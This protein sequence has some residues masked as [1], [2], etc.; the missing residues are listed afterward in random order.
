MLEGA[1]RKIL[2]GSWILV[3]LQES[4]VCDVKYSIVIVFRLP[5]VVRCSVYSAAPIF[6]WLV[7]S[8]N[9][10]QH[11]SVV[12]EISPGICYIPTRS[13]VHCEVMKNIHY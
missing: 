10:V 11:Y 9:L 5:I 4:S 12:F 7:C 1:I 13:V 3:L 8:P 2:S 6:M